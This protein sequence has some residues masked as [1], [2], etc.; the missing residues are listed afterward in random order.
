MC[1]ELKP[2]LDATLEF[3]AF[4]RK[5]SLFPFLWNELIHGHNKA[6]LPCAVSSDPSFATVPVL[7]SSDTVNVEFGSWKVSSCVLFHRPRIL[8]SSSTLSV[9]GDP[10]WVC[11]L[12][13]GSLEGLQLGRRA[14]P[15]RSGCL[16]ER[17]ASWA[18]R[19]AAS[20]PRRRGSS[21]HS[22]WVLLS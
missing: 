4:D 19:G 15:G 7:G 9:A 12:G 1:S 17:G 6:D 3:W 13:P 10:V 22:C 11:L 5:Y 2:Q 20:L 21:F 16:H 8:H 14:A 18:G